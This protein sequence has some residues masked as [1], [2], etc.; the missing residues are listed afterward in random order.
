MKKL[1]H[2]IIFALTVVLVILLIE[3]IQFTL[4][5]IT[6]MYVAQLISW[7]VA[8]MVLYLIVFKESK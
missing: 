7:I 8:M 4:S 3:V 5:Y 2:S 6:P 1:L